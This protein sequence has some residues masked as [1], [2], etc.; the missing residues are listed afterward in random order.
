MM[1]DEVRKLFSDFKTQYYDTR[2]EI[3]SKYVKLISELNDSMTNGTFKGSYKD[4]KREYSKLET[5]K[6]KEINYRTR[7]LMG[8]GVSEFQDIYDAL[9]GGM[10]RDDGTVLFGPGSTYYR[11]R[12]NRIE[13]TIANYASLSVTRPDLI[14]LL[15]KDK[16]E[17]SAE[18][19]S[20]IIDLLKKARGET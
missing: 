18:L 7:N 17:L 11:S 4:Y 12:E 1:S 6:E 2:R 14:A 8:G 20:A 19:D 3:S 13:E 9:S 5:A 15:K 10:Y 16:P